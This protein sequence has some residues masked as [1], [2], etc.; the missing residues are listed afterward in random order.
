MQSLEDAAYAMYEAIDITVA[1]NTVLPLYPTAASASFWKSWILAESQRRTF[2]ACFC[3][4]S[5]YALLREQLQYC[6][7]HAALLSVYTASAH[8]WNARSVFDF[9]RA[10][11]EEKHFVVR[12]LD[13]SQ[14]LAE[15][16]AE[17]VDM[18]SKMILAAYIGVDDLKGWLHVR[19]GSLDA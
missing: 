4:L 17:D 15:A 7:Q 18:F 3:L 16:R 2:L 6:R 19:G 1:E 9:A 12:E 10:W 5:L 11:A 8:L 14:V 13:M